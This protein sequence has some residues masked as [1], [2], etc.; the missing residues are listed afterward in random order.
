[1]NTAGATLASTAK[2]GNRWRLLGKTLTCQ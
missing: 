2:I 1:V